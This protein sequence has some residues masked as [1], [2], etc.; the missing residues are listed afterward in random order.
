MALCAA[1]PAFAVAAP[2]VTVDLA[3]AVDALRI[4]AADLFDRA[5]VRAASCDVNGDGIDDVIVGADHANG[6]DESRFGAGEVY[7]LLGRRAAWRGPRTF[8]TAP[9]VRIIGE[10]NGDVFGMG[11]GCGDLDGDGVN[12]LVLA[13]PYADRLRASGWITGTVHLVRGGPF[14]PPLID[15]L[16][17]SET[18]IYADQQATEFGRTPVV[19]DLDGDGTLDLAVSEEYAYDRTGTKS[20]AGRA[21]VL[22]GRAF[23]PEGLDLSELADVTIYGAS[24][25]DKLGNDLAAGDLDG[26]GTSDLLVVGIGGD[27]PT[28]GREAAGD[29]NVFR[30]RSSWPSVIDLATTQPDMLVF[31]ADP[32]DQ[33]GGVC[34]LKVMDLDG[35]ATQDVMIG[36]G[37]AD[38]KNNAK[39]D[40]GEVRR[41]EPGASWPATW[42]LRTRTDTVIWPATRGDLLGRYVVPGDVNADG[43]IDAAISAGEADGPG[44]SRP[45]AGEVVV[46]YG[47]ESFASAYDLGAGA[48]DILIYGPAAGDRLI[49]TATSDVNGDGYAELVLASAQ[50]SQTKLS[51]TWLVSPFDADGDGISQLPD[52]C[53]LVFNPDQ[54]DGDGDDRGDACATDWDGDGADDVIDCAPIDPQAGTPPEV[55]G[56]GFEPGDT[57]ALIWLPAALADRYDVA[58]I[59]LPRTADDDYG[60]CVTARDPD[61][62]DT[63]FAD[64]EAP[65]PGHGY[66]YLVRGYDAP[67]AAA[68]TW[69]ATSSGAE[70]T[71]GNAA[72]CP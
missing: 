49:V 29:I 61:P 45:G 68:G 53:P 44:E 23:W 54:A 64:G 1:A 38:G 36:T 60:A 59:D 9:D 43:R 17:Q 35:D 21:F 31:G 6:E 47:R 22:F 2:T 14:L 50:D 63:R 42:D 67:C 25:N 72:G 15:L 57:T 4:D 8:S 41:I 30:G 20:G 70:R 40:G 51:S 65:E 32:D 56:V 18:V 26:D 16:V 19:A 34:G 55:A 12:E 13:A 24:T 66:A 7:V 62:A 11:V 52:N 28:D 5:G 27:G 10:L 69:G 71:N 48:G 46:F 39:L 58:R 33:A 37:L 3:T